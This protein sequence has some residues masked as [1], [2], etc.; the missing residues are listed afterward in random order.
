MK[1]RCIIPCTTINS[2]SDNI[3]DESNEMVYDSFINGPMID[4]SLSLCNKFNLDPIIITHK[5]KTDLIDYVKDKTEIL[6]VDNTVTDY[7]QSV[8]LSKGYWYNQ[9]ILLL[10]NIRFEPENALESLASFGS[11]KVVLGVHT[12]ENSTKYGAIKI[13]DEE[14]FYAN[15][16]LTNETN[17]A[18]G[19]ISFKYDYG[20]ELF[21]N[22]LDKNKWHKFHYETNFVFLN[23]FL[24][25]NRTNRIISIK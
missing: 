24:D 18:W 5:N 17:F 14:V 10:P 21:N 15:K 13:K 16:P 12:V 8:L 9:N 7:F 19:L 2:K 23:N 11:S 1:I 20:I 25:V 4:Y 22:M 6:I 3:K